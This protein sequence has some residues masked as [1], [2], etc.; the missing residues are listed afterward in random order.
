MKKQ[1]HIF[2][3]G[4]LGFIINIGI[5]NPM[6]AQ[7]RNY[8]TY[9]SS[10]SYT[11]N[12]TYAGDA[13]MSTH[14]VLKGK[15]GLL[16]GIGATSGYVTTTY[17]SALPSGTEL[18]IGLSQDGDF[19]LLKTLLGGSLGALINGVLGDLVLGTPKIKIELLNS[20][21]TAVQTKTI[22]GASA[23][24][25]YIGSD[26]IMYLQVT[27]T[28][29]FKSVRVS[30]LNDALLGIGS[31]L[32]NSEVVLNFHDVFYF[33]GTPAACEDFVTTSFDATGLSLSL[34]NDNPNP[35]LNP[36]YAIDN[37]P[38]TYSELG[39][40][41]PVGAYVGATISQTVYFNNES[42]ADEEVVITFGRNSTLLTLDL[43]DNISIK[44]LNGAT[45]VFDNT[46][47]SL[48]SLEALGILSVKIGS[49]TPDKISI[50][51]TGAFDRVIISYTQVIGAS[52]LNDP[53]KLY[54]VSK[55]PR[56]PQL[57]SYTYAGCEGLTT[58]LAVLDPI[59]T[60][61]YEWLDAD[62]NVIH[63][64][65]T[66]DYTYPTNGTSDTI[67]V[68]SENTCSQTSAFRPI[69]ISGNDALCLSSIVE[70][71][72][73]MS[74]YTTSGFLKAVATASN[75]VLAIDNVNMATG[76]YEFSP[77]TKGDYN[78]YIVNY[79][80]DI[81]DVLMENSVDAGF[82]VVEPF[83][84]VSV[85]GDGLPVVA[86][87]FT[88]ISAPLNIVLKNFSVIK[89][90]ESAILDWEVATLENIQAFTIEKSYNGVDFE[91]VGRLST[92]GQLN[93]QF[94]DG[95]MKMGTQ[96]YRVGITAK[97]GTINYSEVKILDNNSLNNNYTLFPNPAHTS[98][99]ID[100]LIGTE[101]IRVV[102]M[103]GKQQ[104]VINAKAGVNQIAVQQLANGIYTIHIMNE[105]K[106]L[107]SMQ[108]VKQ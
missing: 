57:S 102:G 26:G 75:M 95:D 101:T 76:E 49:T 17:P 60:A 28:V 41:A 100:H 42:T 103:D 13:D 50:P 45:V 6:Q 36:E 38:V 53:L 88:I 54:D 16:F 91:K 33:S 4:L 90:Q 105:N 29:A 94:V 99:Q 20:S 98:I 51:V 79:M 73:D 56:I 19:T 96:Y 67:F 77:M 108:F 48:L 93:Y 15:A 74:A 61:T 39:Y 8:A 58:E 84:T 9:A 86:A 69:V 87:P 107:S 2:I 71:P 34:L 18:H 81:G 72:V 89:Q 32:A 70:G 35:V 78:V 83:I 85:I 10:N 14:A 68:Y 92:N 23:E 11:T 30:A 43:L 40:A 82:D 97:N 64:G 63:T 80:V 62:F 12:P 22:S 1:L 47:S 65:A 37:N 59:A 104:L 66:F 31:V 7:T 24:Q 5:S 106:T 46:A 25:V 3:M 21:G 55:A 52:V 44:V 27:S